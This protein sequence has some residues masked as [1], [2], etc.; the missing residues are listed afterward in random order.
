MT[1]LKKNGENLSVG[2]NF[3]EPVPS[4]VGVGAGKISSYEDHNESYCN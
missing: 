1:V 2:Q 3:P 4:R